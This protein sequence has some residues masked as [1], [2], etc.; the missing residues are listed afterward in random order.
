MLVSVPF[1]GSV[2]LNK[3]VIDLLNEV[4]EVSVPFRG[5]VF[6]NI[7]EKDTT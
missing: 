1:R 2:F 4:V 5:S 7:I 6:L 3:K